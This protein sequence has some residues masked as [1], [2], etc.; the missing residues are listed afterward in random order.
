[1]H[2]IEE[3]FLPFLYLQPYSLYAHAPKASPSYGVISSK[4]KC[5]SSLAKYDIVGELF[6]FLEGFH[7]PEKQTGS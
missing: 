3:V 6:F 4:Q 1:M 2:I 7:D 5:A